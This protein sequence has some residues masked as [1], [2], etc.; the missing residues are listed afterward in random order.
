M[1]IE[2]TFNGARNGL[3][4]LHAYINTVAQEIGMERALALDTKVNEALG[5]TQ[6]KMIKEHVGIEEFD[7]KAAHQPLI[8][9]IEEGF[10]ILSE[11]IEESPQRVV[12][13]V[14]R[15]PVY[16]AAQAL[17]MDAEAIEANCRAT[18]IRYMEAMARQL[19]P[20]LS[21][22]LRKFRSAADDSCEEAIVLT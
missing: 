2:D 3:T 7:A 9:A 4:F 22:E 21:Y 1:A 19:N 13:K 6:G 14:G 15:C 16:E 12:F 17:G 8:N 20:N 11:V 5:A 18:S 10:G